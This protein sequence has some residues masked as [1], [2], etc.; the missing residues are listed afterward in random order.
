MRVY[1]MLLVGGLALPA[2][3]ATTQEAV[4]PGEPK[5]GEIAPPVAYV[6]EHEGTFG[7]QRMRYKATVGETFLKDAKGE[8][9]AAIVSIAYIAKTDGDVADRPVTFLWNGGPGSSSLWLHMGAFGPKR[10]VVPSDGEDDGAPPYRIVD[11]P[12]APLDVTDL[13]FV[14]PV[15]TG[16]SRPLGSHEGA[17]FWGVAEDGRAMAEFIRTWLSANGRWASPKYIGGESY[18]TTRAAVVAQELGSWSAPVAL[19]GILLI[20]T[21]LDFYTSGFSVGNE[22]GY[23]TSLPTMAATAWHHGKV[24]PR[25]ADLEEFLAQARAFAV[26]EYLPALF[27]GSRLEGERR[28]RIRDRLAYFTGISPQYFD[29]SDLR[30][31]DQRFYKELLRDSGLV[32]GRLDSRYTGREIDHAGEEPE[33]DPSMYGITGAYTAAIHS[34]LQG[35]LG[36]RFERPYQVFGSVFGSWKWE[37]PEQGFRAF[38]VNV[39]PYLGTAMRQNK[40][41]RLL[42]ASG[43][44]DFATPFFDAE[45][46]LQRNG[47]VP[48]RITYTYYPAGHMMYVHEPSLG[49]LLADVRRFYAEGR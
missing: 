7:G 11:N 30:I 27:Q 29:R 9:T 41:L 33:A 24:E 20:S 43:Y 44:Y 1:S 32:V 13:V 22:I 36:V 18:G 49:Q 4:A 14:D 15:G 46:S 42:V 45:L 23:V 6:S 34:Y 25:P 37:L 2:V 28:L 19:N 21:V 40:D 8:P 10:V 3:A 17:E 5:S 39:A 16:F 48:E 38:N 31:T 35:P 47:L 12:D 26:E